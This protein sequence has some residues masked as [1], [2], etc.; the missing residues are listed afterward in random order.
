MNISSVNKLNNQYRALVNQAEMVRIQ[1]GDLPSNEEGL[2]YQNAAE[3]CGQ[4]A[5]M[6]IGSESEHWVK[7]QQS[8]QREMRKIWAELHPEEKKAAKPAADAKPSGAAAPAADGKAASSQKKSD[9]DPEVIKSWYLTEKPKHTLDDVAGLEDA[10]KLM[11]SCIASSEMRDLADYLNLPTI[12][13][14]FFYGPPGC[15]KTY[16]IK[17]FIRELMDKGYDCLSVD[18]GDIHAK[19]SG[20]ADK[21]LK[22]LFNEAVSKDKC[23]IFIDEIDGIC[24][25]RELPNLSDF[26]MQLTTTF[27]N[28]FNRLVEAGRERKSIFFIAATNYP[29]NVDTA[30]LDRVQLIQIPMPGYEMRES[31]FRKNLEKL[32]LEDGLSFADFAEKSEG[33]SVRDIDRIVQNTLQLAFNSLCEI[34]AGGEN[35]A[36]VAVDMLK[37]GEFKFTRELFDEVFESYKPKPNADIERSLNE[38]E[39]KA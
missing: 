16:S 36:S 13:S 4:L 20:E 29:S 5:S 39:A 33:F 2:C 34:Y 27:L 1:N 7:E 11:R 24:Q 38:F 8:C 15:G 18:S 9:I 26:N 25:N 35:S 19:F 10:K 37:N 23:V 28:C 22:A 6:T 3:I 31:I 30:M 12:H 17:G 32:T 21:R 14:F